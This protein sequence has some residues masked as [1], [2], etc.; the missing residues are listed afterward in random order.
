LR[1]G[2]FDTQE[3]VRVVATQLPSALLT[4][5]PDILAAEHR[6]TAAHADIGAARAAFFPHLRRSTA[7]VRFKRLDC[8][9]KLSYTDVRK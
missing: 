8:P 1:T 5:R 7:K 9:G 3:S 6:L 2:T 4:Q